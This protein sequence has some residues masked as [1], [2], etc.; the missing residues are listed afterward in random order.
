[1]LI[2]IVEVVAESCGTEAVKADLSV[3][4]KRDLM[5]DHAVLTTFVEGGSWRE[6]RIE[7]NAD[8]SV[9][10]CMVPMVGNGTNL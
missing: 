1:M 9:F 5:L 10:W 4:V 2:S 8:M 7:V 3:K 6:R